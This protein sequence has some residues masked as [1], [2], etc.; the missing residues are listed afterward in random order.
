MHIGYF[1]SVAEWIVSGG[2]RQLWLRF[3]AVVVAAFALGLIM[4]WKDGDLTAFWWAP[5]AFYALVV[6]TGFGLWRV[7]ERRRRAAR[8]RQKSTTLLDLG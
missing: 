4:D 2:P 7:M 5:P 6:G 8:L 3:G 1:Q